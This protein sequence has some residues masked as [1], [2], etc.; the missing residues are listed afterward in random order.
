M[1]K[2][3]GSSPLT[4]TRCCCMLLPCR[5]ARVRRAHDPPSHHLQAARV[6]QRVPRAATAGKLWSSGVLLLASVTTASAPPLCRCSRAMETLDT[7]HL[8]AAALSPSPSLPNTRPRT[9][10]HPPWPPFTAQVDRHQ[11]GS[12]GLG[13][14][15]G[16]GA[17]ARQGRAGG[18]VVQAGRGRG[19]GGEQKEEKGAGGRAGS[20]RSVVPQLHRV[21]LC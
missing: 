4:R 1:D 2:R 6:P 12:G 21:H 9:C 17:G 5:E 13:G 16:R 19:H 10:F 11:A 3:A 15:A 14:A 18:A 8:P 7:L 20:G